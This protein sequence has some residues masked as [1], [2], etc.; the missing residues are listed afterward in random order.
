M[1]PGPETVVLVHGLWVHGIAMGL[2]RRRIAHSGYRVL[3]YSYPTV[4][5]TLTE[6][7]Q[8]LARFCRDLAAA[9]LHF[10]GHSLGGLIVLRMLEHAGGIQPGRIVL[11]GVPF[12][13]SHAAHRLGRLPGGRAALGRSM[14][15]WLDTG[16]AGFGTEREI[17]VI[18]GSRPVG[19]GR[20]VAPDLPRPSDGVVS[21][22]ETDVPGMRDHVVIEVC[23]SG[24]LVSGDVARQT[25][26][27][28]RDGAFVRQKKRDR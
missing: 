16:R 25:C 1:G 7:A 24:M 18:A 10:V 5:L 28:L 20:I 6:N 8:R 11:A 23:H 3:V 12:A 22:A 19:L 27:F 17:G 9:R 15:E 14:A 26:A 13:G 2:M 4:R 21:V